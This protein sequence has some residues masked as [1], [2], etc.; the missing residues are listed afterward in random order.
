MWQNRKMF[1]R[2]KGAQ[3]FTSGFGQMVK[4]AYGG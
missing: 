3:R 4:L 1:L 2:V